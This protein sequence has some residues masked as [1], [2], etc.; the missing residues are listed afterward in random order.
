[1]VAPYPYFVRIH[2][3]STVF[4]ISVATMSRTL[5]ASYPGFD[6][7]EIRTDQP[8]GKARL[9][10]VIVVDDAL[11]P[12]LVANAAVCV[13]AA[14]SPR[15]AGMLGPDAIDASGSAHPGLPWAG[16]TV[17]GAPAAGLTRLR[18]AAAETAGV[19][20]AD[21]PAAAQ[22]VRVYDDYLADVAGAAE[23]AYLAVGI[24]GPRDVVDGMTRGLS[25]LR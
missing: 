5:Y 1:M 17:L 10:W 22:R 18:A 3:N 25:L 24:I 14:T 11:P 15:V 23:L 9:K 21:M 20:V 12:G 19:L 13:A 7:A 8:T 2:R 6:A 16:C 4:M